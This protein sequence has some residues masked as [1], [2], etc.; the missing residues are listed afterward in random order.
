MFL[1]TICSL[2]NHG[3]E[4]M[5][6]LEDV[7]AMKSSG[8]IHKA[9]SEEIPMRKRVKASIVTY[10][11]IPTAAR[12]AARI[13]GHWFLYGQKQQRPIFWWARL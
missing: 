12:G 6:N 11:G 13:N 2:D 5:T 7:I 8:M 3:I 10:L 4:Q 1:T 9:L